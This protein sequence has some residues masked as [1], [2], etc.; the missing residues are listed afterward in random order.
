MAFRGVQSNELHQLRTYLQGHRHR[1][2]FLLIYSSCP[3]PEA[4]T[5][6]RIPALEVEVRVP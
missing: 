5:D 2:H 6:D 1:L 4:A 3:R